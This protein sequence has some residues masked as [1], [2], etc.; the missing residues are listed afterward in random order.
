MRVNARNNSY[1][2]TETE[3]LVA[4]SPDDE[5]VLSPDME[6]ITPGVET[7]MGSP[8]PG[9]ATHRRCGILLAFSALH[10]FLGRVMPDYEKELNEQQQAAVKAEPGPIL[11]I[12]GAGSGKTRTLTYRVAYLLEN[13]IPP[14]RLLLLTFTNKAARE[15]LHRVAQLVPQDASKIWGGTF[16]S[17]ANRILRRHAVLLGYTADYSILDR[18]DSKDVMQA[19]L[20]DTGIDIKE[21][22]FPKP[23]LLVELFSLV[24]NTEKPLPGIVEAQY[25]HFAPLVE[26]MQRVQQLYTARKK[27]LN[28]MDYDDLLL[29]L[30]I[31]LKDHPEAAEAYGRQFLAIL[32]DE[33]QDTNLMQARIVDLVA[34]R[35]RNVMVV[36]DDAQSIF[37]WRGAN[38]Q[39]I[40]EFPKRYP[41][42]RIFKIES[43]YRSTPQILDLAN[44]AI[45]TNRQQYE[46]LLR[47]V[48]KAGVKPVVL[49]VLHPGEQASFVAAQMLELRDQG[50]SLN[51][52]AVLY[53]SH[54]HSMELQMELTRRNIPFVITSGL[55][56]FE[57]AHVKDVAAYLK[58]AV[59]PSD[60]LAFKRIVRLMPKI[61]GA[62]AGKLWKAAGARRSK[63]T[64][65]GGGPDYLTILD[66]VPKPAREMWKQFAET[67]VQLRKPGLDRDPSA[68]IHLVLDAGYEDHLQSKY[69]N[70]HSRREDL[71]QLAT[72][73]ARFKKVQDFLAELALMTNVEAEEG[74]PE[75]GE[76]REMVRLSTVHQAKGQEFAVVFVI[77]LADG[78]FPHAR[79]LATLGGE[80]EERRLFYVAVT[81]C[82]DELYLLWPQMRPDSRDGNA[83][84]KP[85]RF[86]QEISKKFYDRV[87]LQPQELAYG[88]RKPGRF[89]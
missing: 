18:E 38:M 17:V 25:S 49:Q 82:K 35:H 72:Y 34:A 56:F 28:A 58:L 13:G 20:A 64:A 2:T 70:F 15:M 54:F 80:E 27:T 24:V 14:D 51:D 59:N 42:A 53:R 16:H 87:E 22:R 31:L 3:R 1:R 41:G 11:V 62:T 77:G 8:G 45:A 6:N 81:R 33:Y 23:E 74:R 36:G 37:S 5:I 29:N 61:G 30:Q 88:S 83:F 10:G 79:A 67:M 43:N 85:S 32:V 9:A 68:M 66:A 63:S 65:P 48:R 75:A 50:L 19:C 55:R 46:K 76:D 12:A 89:D 4:G 47:A 60:E 40:L 69:E 7:T 26:D 84:Q 21:T 71:E 52:M 86:L 78:A 57:Q 39:N 73:A 44:D